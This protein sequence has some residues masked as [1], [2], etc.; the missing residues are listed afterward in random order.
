MNILK[1]VALRACHRRGVEPYTKTY[2]FP[3]N[4][5][6]AEAM[7]EINEVIGDFESLVHEAEQEVLENGTLGT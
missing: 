1:A 3:H 2:E 6:L 5:H 4:T 7:T